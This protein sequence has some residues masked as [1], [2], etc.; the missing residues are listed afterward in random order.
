MVHIITDSILNERRR[1]NL[2]F[3][4][5]AGNG[6]FDLGRDHLDN[7]VVNFRLIAEANFPFGRMD[8]EIHKARIDRDEQVAVGERPARQE[9]GIAVCYRLNQGILINRPLIYK[10][11]DMRAV[12]PPQG[13][14]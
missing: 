8:I 14:G 5:K 3:F 11:L 10:D 12:A 6:S 1:G 4:L 13:G 7:P 2:L 9:A